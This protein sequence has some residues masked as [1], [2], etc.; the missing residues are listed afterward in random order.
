MAE[1]ETST[2][3][4]STDSGLAEKVDGLIATLGKLLEGG[5]LTV[6]D[7]T[8]STSTPQDED[9][10]LSPR[11]EERRWHNMVASAVQELKAAAKPEPEKKEEKAPPE[12]TPHSAIRR[13]E[14][15]MGWSK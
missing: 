10:T 11:E 13:V 14:K 8:P 1:E 4:G 12:T 9:E 5:Q 2:S 7:K 6:D 3:P 15:L